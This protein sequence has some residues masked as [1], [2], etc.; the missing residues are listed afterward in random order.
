MPDIITATS[1]RR[2]RWPW[3]VAHMGKKSRRKEGN[4]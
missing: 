2:M 3:K 1:G 4:N